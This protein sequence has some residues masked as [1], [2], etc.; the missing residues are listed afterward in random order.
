MKKVLCICLAFLFCFMTAG[1]AAEATTS[2]DISGAELFGKEEN[3]NYENAFIGLGFKLED[4]HLYTDEE[5]DA[6]N[7]L[8]KALLT[9]DYSKMMEQIDV[10]YVMMAVDSATGTNINIALNNLGGMASIYDVMGMEYIATNNV[11]PSISMM[12]AS[13]YQDVAVEYAKTTIDGEEYHGLATSYKLQAFNMKSRLIMF[14]RD[15]YLV[16]VT[17]TGF[18]DEAVNECFERLYHLK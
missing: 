17:V 4:W 15:R 7:N 10:I 5:I 8:S 16:S 9:E 18:T 6:M 14:I 11:D 2:D 13:G 12:K 1:Y 3:G